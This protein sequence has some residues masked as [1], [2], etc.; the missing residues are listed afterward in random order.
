MAKRDFRVFAKRYGVLAFASLACAF[1]YTTFVDWGGLYPG[2]ATGLSIFLQRLAQRFCDVAGIDFTVPFSP[3]SLVL[4]GIPAY[5]G[6]RYI[7]KRFTIRSVAV[8]VMTS[9]F[10]DLLPKETIESL[11]PAAELA[12]LKSDPFVASIF[13]G[14]IFG[15]G[16]SLCLRCQAT[17]GGTDFIAI[18]L[19]EKKGKETWNLILA[20][21]ACILLSAGYEFGWRGSLYS[22]VY[23]FISTQV[24]HLMYRAYQNQT[25]FIVTSRPKKISEAIHRLSHHG[26]TIIEARGSYSDEKKGIV[27]S[28]VA[29]DD[30]AKIYALC[31]T[32]D[33]GAFIGTMN[34]SRVIGRFYMRPRD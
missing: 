9:F 23:Q 2:G 33:P 8:I 15:F 28:V 17:T 1:S 27:Y 4:N 21:N 10:T 24:V 29:A 7:G 30:T 32:I 14:I 31:K 6:F 3:I 20:I 34:A 11:I 19:S 12:R 18:Y 26:A 16:M 5:I 13:G 25:L 22:I